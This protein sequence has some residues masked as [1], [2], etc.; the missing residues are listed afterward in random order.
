ME[1]FSRRLNSVWPERM[2]EILS[3]GQ[4][5]RFVP[6]SITG[7]GSLKRYTG[8]LIFL[9]QGGFRAITFHA[10]EYFKMK[11]SLVVYPLHLVDCHIGIQAREDANIICF[12][13]E[14]LFIDA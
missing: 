6:I 4:E 5:R 11:H 13:P 10:K 2:Q 8:L 3:L 14:H 1:D 9:H 7:T 12:C